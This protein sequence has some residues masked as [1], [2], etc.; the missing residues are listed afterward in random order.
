MDFSELPFIAPKGLLCRGVQKIM[1]VSPS[2]RPSVRDE[3]G[4]W[5]EMRHRFERLPCNADD[6]GPKIGPGRIRAKTRHVSQGLA[7]I[8]D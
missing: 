3:I 4:T 1:F 5:H 6:Q 8:L 2:V 7:I